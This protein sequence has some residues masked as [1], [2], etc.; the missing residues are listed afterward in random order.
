VV[1]K[2]LENSAR[3]ILIYDAECALCVWSKNKIEKWDHRQVIQ[4][5][6]FQTEEAKQHAPELIGLDRLDA[7]RWVESD[8]VIRSGMDAFVKMLPYLPMGR[9]VAF[10][11]RLPG[12]LPFSLWF[13]RVVASNRYRWFGSARASS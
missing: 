7:I 13:Y 10:L 8:G 4:C 5:L 11:F 9:W 12:V 3:P 1:G 2:F 6:P